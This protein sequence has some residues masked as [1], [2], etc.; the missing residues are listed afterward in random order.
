MDKETARAL[1]RLYSLA[2]DV[3][4]DGFMTSSSTMLDMYFHNPKLAIAKTMAKLQGMRARGGPGDIKSKGARGDSATM[5]NWDM[6]DR[7]IG[8]IMDFMDASELDKLD[9]EMQLEFWYGYYGGWAS[10]SVKEAA[11]RLG[12]TEVNVRK[13]IDAG[14]IKADKDGGRWLAWSKSVGQYARKNG[15]EDTEDSGAEEDD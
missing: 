9:G 13:L 5:W 3:A 15:S 10:M 6:L 12:C 2:Y 4:G 7:H 14:K 1:G 8:N 11:E